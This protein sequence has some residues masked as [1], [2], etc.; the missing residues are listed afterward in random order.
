MAS[1]SS[2]KRQKRTDLKNTNIDKL[3]DMSVSGPSPTAN[4]LSRK[5]RD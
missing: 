3:K 5:N 4:I 2:P 1:D